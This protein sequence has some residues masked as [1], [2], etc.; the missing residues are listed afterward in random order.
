[1]KVTVYSPQS[2]HSTAAE[3]GKHDVFVEQA[4]TGGLGWMRWG[5]RGG[6]LGIVNYWILLH[7]A[8][9]AD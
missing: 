6:Q 2:F 9:W 8:G 4:H 5:C 3:G 7:E 1:M